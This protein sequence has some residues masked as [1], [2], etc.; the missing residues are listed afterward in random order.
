MNRRRFLHYG[1]AVAGGSFIAGGLWARSDFARDTLRSRL[2]E[3][4]LA[5]L[6]SASLRELQGLPIRGREEIRRYFDGK[7][8]NVEPFVQQLCSEGFREQLGQCSTH[9]QRDEFLL[10]AF[11]GRIASEAEILHRV[12]VIAAGI[13]S[14]LD[15]GWAAHGRELST[16]WNVRLRGYGSS[17]GADGLI[18]RASDLVHQELRT[19]LRNAS[20]ADQVPALGQ[21]LRGIGQSA[22]LLLPLVRFREAG[23]AV[24]IPIFV[25]LAAR[26]IWEFV[27]SRL[28]DRRAGYQTAIS[29]QLAL[30][31]NRVGSE[32]EAEIRRRLNDLHTWQ[33]QSI[34]AIADQ[35]VEERVGLI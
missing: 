17:L 14:E 28:E 3:D 24:G 7:C 31:G 9:A 1:A 10:G 6:T 16:R 27:V 20:T 8:L 23:L 32:F 12:D 4:A 13:G 35:L 11:C 22:I 15:T 18:R 29:S 33:Q 5:T 25:F 26:Q 21:M 19:A 30:L 34:R 2:L